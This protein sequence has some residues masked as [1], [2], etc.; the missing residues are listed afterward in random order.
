[1]RLVNLDDV[2]AFVVGDGED[3]QR[4]ALADGLRERFAKPTALPAFGV[5]ECE[6]CGHIVSLTRRGLL[7]NHHAESGKPLGSRAA[8]G[9]CYGRYD[10]PKS[11]LVDGAL[12]SAAT[13]PSTVMPP[14]ATVKR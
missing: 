3:A 6:E 10:R 4:I 13:N 14:A 2:T 1:M 8:P 9:S 7:R 11:T 5:G 12:T